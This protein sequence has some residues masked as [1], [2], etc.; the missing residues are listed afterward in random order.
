M[1]KHASTDDKAGRANLRRR[2]IVAF[3]ADATLWL[4][5]SCVVSE[6]YI[7][8]RESWKVKR[9]S[10]G[11]NA[12]RIIQLRHGFQRLRLQCGKERKSLQRVSAATYIQASWRAILARE[13]A[14]KRFSYI[15]HVDRREMR[16]R[17]RVARA[18]RREWRRREAQRIRRKHGISTD[19]KM[20][21]MTHHELNV[22]WK[23]ENE[24][25]PFSGNP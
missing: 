1:E 4:K 10:I 16:K 25:L 7:Y 21:F 22:F 9:F 2:G 24:A 11:L 3:Q 8:A 23:K 20:F 18:A 19:S 5:H 6:K 13:E 15:L 14:Q 17:M 12:L